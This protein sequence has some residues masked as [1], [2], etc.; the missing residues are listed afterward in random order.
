MGNKCMLFSVFFNTQNELAWNSKYRL[1]NLCW[2]CSS[3]LW[4]VS[5]EFF[6]EE[7]YRFEQ[8]F[9]FDSLVVCLILFSQYLLRSVDVFLMC[10]FWRSF[11][12]WA[13]YGQKK[14]QVFLVSLSAD[15]V[16]LHELYQREIWFA[17][18][19]GFVVYFQLH[20]CFCSK[21][22]WS[23]GDSVMILVWLMFLWCAFPDGGLEFEYTVS[24]LSEVMIS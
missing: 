22:V 18:A 3:L 17:I 14:L 12:V 4:T 2:V 9:K 7:F 11:S 19:V 13:C 1:S 15:F 24:G 6:P 21:D 20:S 16:F 23:W 8:Q 10:S 5:F